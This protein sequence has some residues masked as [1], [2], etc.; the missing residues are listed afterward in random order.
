MAS[1]NHQDNIP[2]ATG[3]DASKK[4]QSPAKTADSREASIRVDGSNVELLLS[5]PNDYP[6]K[7]P[8][9]KFETFCFHPN[10]DVRGHICLDIHQEKWSSAY[11][12]RTILLSIQSS[13]LWVLYMCITEPN[14]SSPLNPQ[15]VQLWS[16]QEE[17][18][19]MVDLVIQRCTSE[20]ETEDL[21]KEL[22]HSSDKSYGDGRVGLENAKISMDDLLSLAKKDDQIERFGVNGQKTRENLI[23]GCGQGWCD[24]VDQGELKIAN[25]GWSVHTFNCRQTVCGTLDYLPPEMV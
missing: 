11:D 17:Y 13:E 20:R 21:R 10:V 4:S 7:P 9:V 14:T 16:N 2:G 6:F 23:A 19:K 1:V 22:H 12:V 8:T 15:A 5:F 3:T 18:R 24:F 25:F